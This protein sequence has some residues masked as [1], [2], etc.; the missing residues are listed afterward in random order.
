M[1][2][3]ILIVDDEPDMLDS[4]ED[5]L[6][7]SRYVVTRARDG[8]QAWEI[9]GTESPTIILSDFQMPRLNGAKLFDL[10]RGSNRNRKIPFI[11]MSATPE[12]ITSVGSYTVLRKPFVFETL[13]QK[14]EFSIA[15]RH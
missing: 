11:F 14:V 3:T 4:I 12:L 9:L 13:I 15:S 2:E 5:A 7:L 1:G 10:V 8:Q 6:T